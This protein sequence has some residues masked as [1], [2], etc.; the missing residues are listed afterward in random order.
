MNNV[1]KNW[2]VTEEDKCA[3][4]YQHNFLVF[5]QNINI[6]ISL[7]T[8]NTYISNLEEQEKT[9]PLKYTQPTGKIN[10][11]VQNSFEDEYKQINCDSS[12]LEELEPQEYRTVGHNWK[13]STKLFSTELKCYQELYKMDFNNLQ[14]MY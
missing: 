11:L 1:V 10:G 5:N 3:N 2:T 4:I 6:K 8:L 13:Q 9:F 14:N 12:K 7:N